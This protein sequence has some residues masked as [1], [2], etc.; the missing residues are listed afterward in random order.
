MYEVHASGTFDRF[1]AIPHIGKAAQQAGITDLAAYYARLMYPRELLEVAGAYFQCA[2]QDQGFTRSEQTARVG[3]L[4]RAMSSPGFDELHPIRQLAFA[5]AV[6]SGHIDSVLGLD[7]MQCE[8]LVARFLLSRDPPI[9][10]ELTRQGL[11]DTRLRTR[12]LTLLSDFEPSR[13]SHAAE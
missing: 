9:L 6:M 13:A 8:A 10:E 5:M 1:C 2:M 12:F 3:F 11:F 7:P 4:Q